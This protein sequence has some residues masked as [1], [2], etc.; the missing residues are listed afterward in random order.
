MGIVYIVLESNQPR[1]IQ[2]IET[3]PSSSPSFDSMRIPATPTQ[4]HPVILPACPPLLEAKPNDGLIMV[5]G[6]KIFQFYS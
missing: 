2:S 5:L 4:F 3:T 6:S 1:G